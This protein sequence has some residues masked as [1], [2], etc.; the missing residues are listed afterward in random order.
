MGIGVRHTILF[1]LVVSSVAIYLPHAGGCGPGPCSLGGSYDFLGDPA[2]SID[3]P[4]Y[5]EFVRD[6]L[7]NNQPLLSTKSVSQKAPTNNSSSLNQTISGNVSQNSSA[8]LRV[9][10][11]PVNTTSN[12]TKS[13]NATSD[14][15]IVK[16]GASG[17][18]DKR[19]TTMA[20]T[21]FDNNMF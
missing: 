15:K 17:T 9:I 3:M 2:V 14:S 13:D 7:G 10:D 16:L 11:S 4:G 5:D 19:L 6:N 20:L 1:L 12:N 8:A 18:Q 21:T